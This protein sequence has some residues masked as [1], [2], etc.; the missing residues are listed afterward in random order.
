MSNKISRIKKIT[1]LAETKFLSLYNAEYLNKK[2]VTRHWTVASRKD[3]ETLNAQFF[4]GK[5]E[6]IDAVIIVAL[7][8]DSKKLVLVKQFRVPLNDYVYE[9]PAGLV[10]GDEDMLKAVERELK[11]ETGLKVVKINT[12]KTTKGLYVSVGMTDESVALV[13]CVCEGEVS[14]D[15]LEDDEDIEV[16]MVSQEEAKELL[17]KDIKFDIKVYMILQS[18]V[19]MGE[20]LVD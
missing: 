19:A 20:K 18:F 6:K 13:Y 16:V 11:E 15:Y 10:D 17:K 14:K 8:K 1:P 4:E 12:S 9:L 5:E 3:I 7:H 2:G